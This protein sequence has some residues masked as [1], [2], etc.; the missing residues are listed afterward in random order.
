MKAFLLSALVGV[1]G[2][3]VVT[4]IVGFP[5]ITAKQKDARSGWNPKPV[6]LVS[7]DVAAGELLSSDAL[8]DGVLP[9]QF[10]SASTVAPGDR[11]IVIGQ[12]TGMPLKSGDALVWG[13]FITAVDASRN[14]AC[15]EQIRP[16]ATAAAL[17]AGQTAV[18]RFERRIVARLPPQSKLPPAPSPNAAGM[19]SVVVAAS[20]L[21]EESVLAATHLRLRAIPRQFVTASHVFEADLAAIVGARLSRP[22]LAGDP[23]MWQLL[24]D[25]SVPRSVS[26]CVSE[27]STAWTAALKERAAEEAT[28]FVLQELQ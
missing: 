18:D 26:S 11:S 20:D 6:L 9:E 15:I 19:I 2:A 22:M 17:A 4:S 12:K 28:A 13:A 3:A 1:L 23:V 7:H 10:V 16:S 5:V 27:A 8:S 25:P 14:S 24:D 21:N